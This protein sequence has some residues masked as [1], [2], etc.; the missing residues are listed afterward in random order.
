C[1]KKDVSTLEPTHA[2]QTPS[3][4]PSAASYFDM[5]P[6]DIVTPRSP[7]VL[8]P[9]SLTFSD[10]TLSD[11]GS[12]TEH[13]EH[14]FG[15]GDSD[16]A[17]YLSQLHSQSYS[18]ELKSSRRPRVNR[19]LTATESRIPSLSNTPS[20]SVGTSAS[21]S[22]CKPL[23]PADTG[24]YPTTAQSSPT[25]FMKD[26]S[27]KSSASTLTSFNVAEA[28]D[29]SFRKRTFSWGRSDQAG[30]LKHLFSHEAM[31]S[32]PKER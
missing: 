10:A 14:H 20:S 4:I 24:R 1:R 17:R 13:Y 5:P 23:P 11:N 26:A 27:L 31:R 29:V 30:S 32:A 18:G 22:S 21:T 7:T 25:Q 3:T 28:T 19:A 16:S 12:P 6:T 9:V 8:R 15:R 2:I